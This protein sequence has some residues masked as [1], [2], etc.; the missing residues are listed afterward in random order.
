[1]SAVLGYYMAQNVVLKENNMKILVSS[2]SGDAKEILEKL[3]ILAVPS[4]MEYDGNEPKPPIYELEI[5]SLEDLFH[6]PEILGH[7]LIINQLGILEIYN[8]YRE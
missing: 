6:M 2:T 8:D 7:D 3:G 5:D 1:M 4:E